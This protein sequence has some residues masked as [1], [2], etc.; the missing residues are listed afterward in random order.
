MPGPDGKIGLAEIR[1][2]DSPIMLADEFPQH[3][4]RGPKALGSTTVSVLLYLDNVD[5]RIKRAVA[6]G[7]KI[8]SN[9]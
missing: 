7:A 9:T 1:I 5:A 2:G 8:L 4:F 3:G 6:A